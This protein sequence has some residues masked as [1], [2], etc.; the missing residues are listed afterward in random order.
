[1]N[2]AP[3]EE[4]S[5]K[6]VLNRKAFETIEWLFTSLNKGR[7]TQDQFSTGVDALFMAVSGLVDQDFISM[8]TEAQTACAVDKPIVK[9][10][11]YNAEGSKYD[12]MRLTWVVG[13]DRVTWVNLIG[14]NVASGRV[15]LFDSSKEVAKFIEAVAV[16]MEEKGWV[17]L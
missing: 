8:I 4:Y 16:K 17:E 5:T 14:A 11:F 7:L 12:H 15:V 9:K 2:T 10:I 3:L 1:M 6:V 13:E